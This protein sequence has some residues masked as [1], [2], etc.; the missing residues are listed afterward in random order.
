MVYDCFNRIDANN[1]APIEYWDVNFIHVWDNDAEDFAD[2]T[3]E[4]LF[5]SLPDGVSIGNPSFAKNSPNILAFDYIDEEADEYSI[6]GCNIE[7]NDVNVIVENNTLGWPSYNKT[8]GRL[9]FTTLDET[10]DSK[11]AHVLLNADK[12]SASGDMVGM[13]RFTQWPVYFAAGERQI[14]EEVITGVPEN[15]EEQSMLSCYPNPFIGEVKVAITDP[16]LA[17]GS[18]FV[19]NAAGQIVYE[20]L[21]NTQGDGY[22]LIDL[23]KLKSGLYYVQLTSSTKS[24]GCKLVKK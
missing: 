19:L 14:G 4:K 8:D 16:L 20:G 6:L 7:T 3:I 10:N 15:V 9:A 18:V 2:G 12:I 24:A 1:A 11:V 5:S 13:F 17:S 22:F 21:A 23:Q